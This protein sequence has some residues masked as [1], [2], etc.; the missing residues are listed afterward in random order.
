MK[1]KVY[2]IG[3][4]ICDIIFKDNQPQT[5]KAG[6]STFNAMVSLGRMGV[7]TSFI[8]KIGDDKIGRIIVDFMHQNHIS[9]SNLSIWEGHKT[10]IALAFL[11][12]KGDAEYSF[13]KEFDKQFVEA[14]IPD[15][16]KDDILLFGSYFALNPLLRPLVEKVLEAAKAAEAIVYYDPN[17]RSS[18]LHEIEALRATL[19]ANFERAT[20][21]RGSDE[22]F[23]NIFGL[24]EQEELR[25]QFSTIAPQFII[26]KNSEGVVVCDKDDTY[27]FSAEALIPVSTIGAGDS[28]NAGFIYAL[29]KYD[30]GV[31][32]L[33]NMSEEQWASLINTAVSFATD[34]C[35]SYD[36]YISVDFAEKMRKHII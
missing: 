31:E 5:A 13:Y 9:T 36:N 29:L 10:D 14:D 28:F 12:A 3:E 26:T 4:T 15:F 2:G 32:Q 35:Q 25:K 19:M 16:K 17:F 6:G 8:S 24:S 34:V 21:V 27:H 20:V 30:I 1:R 33:K 11:N 7:D 22:D 18:H 23:Q